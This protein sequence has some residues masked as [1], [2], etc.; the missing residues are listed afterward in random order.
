MHGGDIYRKKI[1][2]DY[3]VNINPYGIPKSVMEAMQEALNNVQRY[4]DIRCE[5]LINMLTEKFSCE[6]GQIVCGNGASELIM[7]V[8]HAIRPKRALLYAPGFSGYRYALKT[9]DC[10]IINCYDYRQME[11]TIAGEKPDIV[12][13]TN[14]NNPTGQLI[15]PDTVKKIK[16]ACAA[17][18]STLLIDECFIELTGRPDEYS[19]VQD[20][21]QQDE[22]NN[23]I[24]LRAFT[25]S[26]AIPGVR[27]GYALFSSKALAEKVRS[28]I[29]EWNVSVIAQSAAKACLNETEFVKRSA[30]LIAKERKFLSDG[31]IKN[32]YNVFSSDANFILFED[33]SET[34]GKGFTGGDRRLYD[35][36][37]DKGILIRDCSDYEGLVPGYY[38]IAVKTHEENITLL[39]QLLSLE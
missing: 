23:V 25:K 38:R 1:N 8:C 3:S 10:G 15:S 33:V 29:P 12:F 32:K 9:V 30:K 35:R 5:E 4:P 2:M 14:P 39:N 19:S 37:I 24:I 6:N 20:I 16:K 18:G 11:E 27:I 7:A 34:A 17:A 22:E 13:I 36:M 31:L 26:F 28:N 21:K